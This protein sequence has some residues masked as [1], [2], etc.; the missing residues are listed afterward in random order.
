MILAEV[1]IAVKIRANLRAR[2]APG[3]ERCNQ[4][5]RRYRRQILG[6]SLSQFR[7]VVSIDR[8]T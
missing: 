8:L 4:Q 3:H 1:S 2:G 6:D 5:R 7:P